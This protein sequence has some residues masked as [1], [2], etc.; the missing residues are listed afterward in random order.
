MNLSG[1]A[2]ILWDAAVDLACAAGSVSPALTSATPTGPARVVLPPMLFFTDPERTPDPCRTAE[3]LP[4][5]S[6]V[7]YRAFGAPEAEVVARR[8]RWVTAERGVRLLIGLDATLA[9]AVGA[10]GVHLPERAAGS[11]A[12]LRLAHPDWLLTAARH[13][14]GADASE[15]LDAL[16]VSPVFQAGGASAATP[17]LG[18]ARF[19]DI[20]RASHLPVY[21]LGGIDADTVASLRDSGACGFAGVDA[22]QR[23]FAD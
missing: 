9:E 13:G 12:A 6:A 21:A 19:T 17:A 3:R 4:T 10:D 22:I 5:G 11:A 7:V 2:R 23:A 14:G 16:V 15:G 8:L 20:V 1:D 18:V